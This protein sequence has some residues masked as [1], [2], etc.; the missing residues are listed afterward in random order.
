MTERHDEALPPLPDAVRFAAKALRTE[1]PSESLMLK[2]RGGL[3]GSQAKPERSVGLQ[4]HAR[5][6]G[7]AAAA[8]GLALGAFAYWQTWIPPVEVLPSRTLSVQLPPT[9]ARMVELPWDFAAHPTGSAQVHLDV[10]RSLSAT[11]DTLLPTPRTTTC[12]GDRCVHRWMARSS[13]PRVRVPV[14][15]E[16]RFE[17]RLRHASRHRHLDEHFVLVSSRERVP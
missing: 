13:L 4:R 15:E 8:C 1:R 14:Q 16:G 6:W 2:V 10:P 9:G 7:L 12:A 17:L 3:I 5:R 11:L